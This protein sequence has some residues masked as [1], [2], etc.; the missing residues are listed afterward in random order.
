M[1]YTEAVISEVQRFGSVL[2]LGVPHRARVNST[3]GEYMIPKG[4]IIFA[5]LH[6]IHHEE[7][8]G[9]PGNFRPE[10][11]FSDDHTCKAHPALVPYSSGRRQCL[12]EGLAKA[13]IF[14]FITTIFQNFDV[15][16]EGDLEDVSEGIVGVTLQPKAFLSTFTRRRGS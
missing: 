10:R 9:D 4:S 6:Y 2:P 3:I 14:L 7:I 16:A 8:W 11:F 12:G 5:N 1:P 13:S 15:H